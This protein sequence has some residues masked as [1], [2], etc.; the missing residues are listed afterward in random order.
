[1][2]ISISFA[3][4]EGESV[5]DAG[6]CR[7]DVEIEFA[8]EPLKDNFQVE[9]AKK[10]AAEAK[11]E[12]HAALLLDMEGRIVELQ[13]DEAHRAALQN[14]RSRQ[15]KSRQ[16]RQGRSMLKPGRGSGAGFLWSVMVSPILTSAVFLMLAMM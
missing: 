8:V 4:V 15:D 16:R 13:F 7:D 14:R 10:A 3:V 1:M 6:G 5:D 9:Q 11:A 12:R 2:S